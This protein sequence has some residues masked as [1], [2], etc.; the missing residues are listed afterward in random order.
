MP[1]IFKVALPRNAVLRAACGVHERSEGA[2]LC[3]KG[4]GV[5]VVE[6]SP[7]TGWV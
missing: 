6:V 4:T 5:G 2:K 7:P 1:F 3:A